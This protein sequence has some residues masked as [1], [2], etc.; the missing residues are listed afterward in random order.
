MDIADAPTARP[1]PL[2]LGTPEAFTRLRSALEDLPFDEASI[3]S[4]V[5]IQSIFEFSTRWEGREQIEL[6][7]VLAALIHLLID[8]DMLD[9]SRLNALV[10]QPVIAA[11]QELG[12]LLRHEQKP[13]MYYSPVALYPVESLYIA[14]DRNSPVDETV[15][16]SVEDAVYAA[17]TVSA[18]RFLASLPP[19][20]CGDVLDLCGGTGIAAF[21][22]AKRYARHAWSCDLS[23]RCTHFA[24]FNRRLNGIENSSIGQG[25]L[26]AAV[27][28]RTFDRIVA[29][30]PYVPTREQ[31]ILYR[32]GGEDGE[33]ILRRI[34]AGLPQHLRPGGRFYSFTLATDREDAD[35]EHRV[36]G[37]LGEDGHEFNVFVVAVE[38]PDEPEYLL[39]SAL[40]STRPVSRTMPNLEFLR[41]LKVRAMYY[42]ITVVERIAESRPTIT[43]RTRKAARATNDAVEWFIRW[44]NAGAASNFDNYLLESRPHL[45]ECFKLQI[46]HSVHQ[47]TLVASRFELK[48][49]YP[50]AVSLPCPSWIA[51]VTALCDGSNRAIDIFEQMRQKK[52]IDETT[53]QQEFAAALRTLLAHGFLELDEFRL[54][55]PP[56]VSSHG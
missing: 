48:S 47:S 3:C 31:K 37:W 17:I 39:K 41:K 49:D 34:V 42:A 36:R 43:A 26:Y 10:P 23:E 56:A 32:D 55:L 14:S 4:R 38:V 12:V 24:E 1:L 9:E 8:G 6:T 40:R 52:V 5:G 13:E 25:D 15:P 50:F 33:K 2:K 7:D 11:L 44:T 18:K 28:G 53:S 30:P 35:Y 21:I 54:P 46:T 27:D 16:F 29:H 19:T 22:A 51:A 20:P 45:A